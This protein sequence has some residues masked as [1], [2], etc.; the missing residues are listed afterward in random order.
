TRIDIAKDLLTTVAKVFPQKALNGTSESV[1]FNFKYRISN[2]AN[3]KYK[4]PLITGYTL[5]SSR[6]EICVYDKKYEVSR[7]RNP[8]K[9]TYYQ[10]YFSLFP[11]ESPITRFEL[12]LK[13]ETCFRLNEVFLNYSIDEATVC[14][15]AYT[16]FSKKHSLKRRPNGSREKDIRRWPVDFAWK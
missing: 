11:E 9:I 6:F 1:L 8:K 10:Q 16:L 12:R 3:I 2:F 7:Q 13:Q 15:H 4:Q 14:R 5:S